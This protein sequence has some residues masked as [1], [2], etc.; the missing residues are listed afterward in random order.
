MHSTYA[1]CAVVCMQHRVRALPLHSDDVVYQVVAEFVPRAA[2]ATNTSSSPATRR[3]APLAPLGSNNILVVQVGFMSNLGFE[4]F[5]QCDTACIL[6]SACDCCL[7]RAVTAIVAFLRQ[8]LGDAREQLANP[9]PLPLNAHTRA[10]HMA[11]APWGHALG[12]ARWSC[13][14][15][16]LG[17]RCAPPLPSRLRAR[18]ELVPTLPSPQTPRTL[19]PRPPP[20]VRHTHPTQAIP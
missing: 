3:L 2:Q 13:A 15:P 8:S 5:P 14:C 7:G 12:S 11:R 10:Q 1:L 9:P 17:S 4:I 19:L 20:P 16:L 6:V 18:A